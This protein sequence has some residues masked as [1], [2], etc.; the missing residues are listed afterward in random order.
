MAEGLRAWAAAA[1][2]RLRR[3]AFALPLAI[4]AAG[5]MMAIS[6]LGYHQSAG[7]LSELVNRGQARLELARLIRRVSEAESSKRGY[8]LTG[9]DEYQ[10][11]YRHASSQSLASLVRLKQLQDHDDPASALPDLAELDERVRIRLAEM[12]AVLTLYNSGQED[13]A[14]IQLMSGMGRDEMDG[15]RSLGD[16]ML[17]RENAR[18][19][20]GLG[21]VF[22]TLQLNR[23]GVALMTAVSLLVLTMYLRQ[24]RQ[25]DEERQARQQ[26]LRE[27]RDRLEEQVRHRTAELTEL[28]R[29]LETAREDE[30][31]RLARDLHDELGALLTAA[32][33]DVARLR[34]KLSA[35]APELLP[36]VAHLVETLNSGIALKRR[37]IEDLRPSSLSNL[38]LLP[39]LEILCGEFAERLGVTLHQRFSP[40]SLSPA[41]ELTVFRLVQESLNNVA[42]HARAKTITVELSALPGQVAVRIQDDG[43]GFDSARV[44]TGRHGL[45]GMRYRVQ[46]EGG[47]L[48]VKASPGQGTELTALLPA[49]TSPANRW[50]PAPAAADAPAA[51]AT[52]T[53]RPTEPPAVPP[54]APATPDPGAATSGSALH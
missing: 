19:A 47:T 48:V 14:H 52:P 2:D 44:G 37:I 40:V 15:I 43:V 24:R 49:G 42:K 6:E 12:D 22:D 26:Q 50:D 17:T 53:E 30:R 28:A 46:A 29:H 18:I 35:A 38:G 54:A 39:A 27:E 36:R 16:A 51:T 13:K 32:K 1:L 10:A 5:M 33:L 41:S 8:L 45:V 3:S 23:V 7:Q 4:L 11:S 21:T 31:A 20:A 25:R 34:P 9:R